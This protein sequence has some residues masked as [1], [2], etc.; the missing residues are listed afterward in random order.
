MARGVL[1]IFI[2]ASRFFFFFFLSLPSNPLSGPFPISESRAV[3][4]CL[5]TKD[6]TIENALVEFYEPHAIA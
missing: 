6:S 1:K 3:I 4:A 5:R 2:P